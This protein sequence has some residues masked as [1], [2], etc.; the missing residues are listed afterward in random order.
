MRPLRGGR[1]AR[2]ASNPGHPDRY[3][4]AK[5]SDLEAT[6]DG[7][8]AEAGVDVIDG[9]VDDILEE[10]TAEGLAQWG[11]K[12]VFEFELEFVVDEVGGAEA[13]ET[14]GTDGAGVELAGTGVHYLTGRSAGGIGDGRGASAKDFVE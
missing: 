1:A 8:G 12:E 4:S 5:N 7:V 14:D 6:G 3:S 9:L 11:G 2:F 10:F 13:D